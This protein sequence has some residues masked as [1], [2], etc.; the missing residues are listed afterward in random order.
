ME[1]V[2]P[3]LEIPELV[4]CLQSCD[5]ALAT[6]ENLIRPTSN[7]VMTLYKQIIENFMGISAD[8]LLQSM[9]VNA[10]E[11]NAATLRTLA[12]NKICFRFFE[13]I[14]VHDFHTLDLCKPDVYRTRRNLS[15]VVNY[16]RFRE[17]RM[18]DCNKFIALMED[19]LS[20]LRAK[21]DNFN[22]IQQQISQ[23]EE[24][25]MAQ[26]R[27]ISTRIPGNDP[28]NL[29]EIEARNS[30]LERELKNLTLLQESL[31]IDY[32]EYKQKKQHLFKELEVVGVQLLEYEQAKE[33]ILKI[34]NTDID[35]IKQEISELK[36]KLTEREESVKS[37]SDKFSNL[38]ESITTFES[39]IDEV[40]DLL[41]LLSND[42]QESSNVEN[43]AISE[44]RQLIQTKSKLKDMLQSSVQYKFDILTEQLENEKKQL[45]RM[46]DEM[47]NQ[48]VENNRAIE[49]LTNEYHQ[50]ILPEK[51]R[52]HTQIIDNMKNEEYAALDSEIKKMESMFNREVNDVEREYSLLAANVNNYIKKMMEVMSS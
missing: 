32:S 46:E 27:D 35:A 7:Y 18:F 47:Q 15:A 26:S 6:E 38:Q 52:I 14:G 39:V 34:S 19:L 9:P 28:T 45:E 4:V 5:F 42:L 2:F 3:L 30:E 29:R 40:Y 13:N 49:K 50:S 31:A 44:N 20:Q 24:E 37:L 10:N 23:Y 41:K 16:A 12:L 22:I 33:Q 21:F 11:P 51:D 36:T 1:D 48:I 43:L 25:E 8:N 17:E